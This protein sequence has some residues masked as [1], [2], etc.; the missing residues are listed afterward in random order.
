[1]NSRPNTQ[2]KRPLYTHFV[3]FMFLIGPMLDMLRILEIDFSPGIDVKVTFR[4]WLTS[5]I[6]T[7]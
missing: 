2:R 3:L 1:M 5:D 7:E 4:I 6:S